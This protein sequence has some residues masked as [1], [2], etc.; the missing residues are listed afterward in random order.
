MKIMVVDDHALVRQ[1]VSALLERESPGA[2]VLEA[3]HSAEALDLAA[4]HDDLDAVFLD[5]TMPG[6]D[7][8]RALAEFARRRPTLP[9]IVLTAADDPELARQAFA[10]GAL[11]YVPKSASAE[12][13]L[14]ALGLVL[15]GETFVPSLVLRAASSDGPAPARPSGGGLTGRQTEVLRHLGEGL[16]NKAIA[17]RMG[18][19]E[20]TVKAH[21]TGV[22]RA[23]A[24]GDRIGAV[25]S[26][27]AAGLI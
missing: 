5:L 20:K 9:V 13:L 18:V 12:T 14:A 15:R 17:A 3:R 2:E 10:A 22:L 16:S 23:M 27:R 8:M 25:Q 21:V 1:G 4:A 19:S 6:M 7:G 26:A 11:G 24:A